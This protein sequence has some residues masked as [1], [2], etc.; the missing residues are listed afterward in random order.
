MALTEENIEKFNHVNESGGSGGVE[1]L[2]GGVGSE[3][4]AGAGVP[5]LS[6]SPALIP[7]PPPDMPDPIA[8]GTSPRMVAM[9]TY[10]SG[11]SYELENG[12]GAAL[13]MRPGGMGESAT[14]KRSAMGSLKVDDRRKSDWSS[15]TAKPRKGSF[16]GDGPRSPP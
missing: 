4:V 12:F 2:E 8:L 10:K 9:S 16:E 1:S 5:G 13:N 6:L 11:G 15:S 14:W 3:G 7:G